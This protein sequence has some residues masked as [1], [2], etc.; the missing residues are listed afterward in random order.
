MI[1]SVY[2]DFGRFVIQ[3]EEYFDRRIHLEIHQRYVLVLIASF[4]FFLFREFGP[5]SNYL[6]IFKMGIFYMMCDGYMSCVN[7][8]NFY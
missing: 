1:E 2:S 4:S 6:S 8:Y 3:T 7:G 5:S